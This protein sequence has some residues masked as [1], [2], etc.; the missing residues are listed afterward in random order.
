MGH[1][2]WRAFEARSDTL[3]PPCRNCISPRPIR[4]SLDLLR[5]PTLLQEPFAFR[6]GTRRDRH[7]RRVRRLAPCVAFPDLARI[8]T[9]LPGWSRLARALVCSL[10]KSSHQRPQQDL[11]WGSSMVHVEPWPT[12]FWRREEEERTAST[13]ETKPL[14]SAQPS[15]LFE[16][17]EYLQ[18]PRRSVLIHLP[19]G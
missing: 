16:I 6:K 2:L 18:R 19:R 11:C 9:A 7:Y 4:R 10:G 3:R 8:C 15:I 12:T 14:Q 1:A 13:T 5:R 17:G